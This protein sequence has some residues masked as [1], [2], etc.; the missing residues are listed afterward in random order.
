MGK[1]YQAA[2]DSEK[3][4]DAFSKSHLIEPDNPDVAREASISAAECAK[5]DLVIAFAER[6]SSLDEADPGLRANLA[7]AYLLSQKPQ[8]AKVHIEAAYA[9]DPAD[10]ITVGVCTV[11]DDVLAGK[12]ACPRHSWEV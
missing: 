4:L 5:L 1:A 7:L 8:I 3:A 9:K 10:Q 12:R 6:A 11:I 2:G